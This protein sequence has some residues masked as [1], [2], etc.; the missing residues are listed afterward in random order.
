MGI[1]KL[2]TTAY[3]PQC[4]GLT[5]RFNRTLKTM[6]RKQA[7]THGLQ[8]DKYLYG[9]LWAYRNTPH[10]S[11]LEKPSFL[12]F[13]MDCRQPT[14][15]AFMPPTPTG[16]L[17]MCDYRQ[18]LVKVLTSARQCAAKTIQKA[19][20]KYKAQYDRTCTVNEKSPQYRIGQW[21]LIR[22]PQEESG[23][24]RKLS[25]PW[26]G[27]FR[28]T[29]VERTGVTA[30]RVYGNAVKDP[31]RVHLQRVTRCPPAFPAGCFWYG[32]RRNGPGRPPKWIDDFV[33]ANTKIGSDDKCDD[34]DDQPGEDHDDQPD[35]EQDDQPDEE[36]DDQ[37]DEEQDDQ[38]D[39]NHDNQPGEE[40]DDQPDKDYDE[41][42][43]VKDQRQGKPNYGK[44]SNGTGQTRPEPKG[45]KMKQMVPSRTRTRDVRPP[46][47]YRS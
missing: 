35:E 33:N 24:N 13:G 26:Y 36:Q 6:L 39:E 27:P 18:E 20:K 38:P 21:V 1:E 43:D 19:Q 12:L 41:Q 2:N 25:R 42:P 31:I 16:S 29:S 11:T 23:P 7:A 4:N 28:I 22:H 34:H 30:K 32:D 45:S 9:V 47:R 5:E 14:E 15:A 44:R 40:H 8:W 37:P 3:H 46:T 17:I 10:E